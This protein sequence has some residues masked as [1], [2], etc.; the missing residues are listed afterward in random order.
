MRD[1]VDRIVRQGVTVEVL[2]PTLVIAECFGPTIQGEGPSTGERAMFVRTSRCNLD[3]AWCDTPFTWDWSGKNGRAY[4]A[5]MESERLTP[6]EVMG[7]LVDLWGTR[8][9]QL[10]VLTGGEPMLQAT[11]IE[12]LCS[13]LV[14]DGFRVEIETNG[15]RAPSVALSTLACFN[16]S[17]KLPHSGVDPAKAIVPVALLDFAN[18]AHAGQAAFKFVV[19][20]VGDLDLV[21]VLVDEYS[22]PYGAVWIMPEGRAHTVID[23]KARALAD[24]VIARGYNL[25]GRMHVELWGDERGR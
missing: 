6:G 22:L 19:Q 3:C 20:D 15:T 8:P 5:S 13:L 25:S 11:Q 1:D 16:V 12:V 14:D 23:Q 7:R 4:V 21:D 9:P 17:P 2:S 24:Q 18:L 10:V